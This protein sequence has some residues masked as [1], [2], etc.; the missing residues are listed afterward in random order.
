MFSV[1]FRL[2]LDF[3]FVAERSFAPFAMQMRAC[4]VSSRLGR[5]SLL[6]PSVLSGRNAARAVTRPIPP[7][8]SALANMAPATKTA[9]QRDAEDSAEAASAAPPATPACGNK[10]LIYNYY[11][12][13]HSTTPCIYKQLLKAIPS[14]SNKSLAMYWKSWM[15]IQ[16][17]IIVA[18]CC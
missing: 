5:S 2:C 6:Y 1:V 3:L 15:M 11:L 10:M 17:R 12:W 9:P 16:T 4:R 18:K 14:I 13:R 8:C 7:Y